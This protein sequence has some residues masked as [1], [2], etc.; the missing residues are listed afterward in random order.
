[1]YQELTRQNFWVKDHTQVYLIGNPVVWWLSSASIAVYLGIR[2]LLVLR[3]KRGYRDLY[4]R[5]FHDALL[6]VH[7]R[8]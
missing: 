4:K 3:E 6:L 2:I 1:M 7:Q 5:E 8:I